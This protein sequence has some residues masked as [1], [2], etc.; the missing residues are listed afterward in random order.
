MLVAVLGP[1]TRESGVSRVTAMT[2]LDSDLQADAFRAA[3]VPD[4]LDGRELGAEMPADHVSQGLVRP[5]HE[6]CHLPAG[7]Q[8][9]VE[10]VAG[11]GGEVAADHHD[12]TLGR[13]QR[14]TRLAAAG[15]GE[16]LLL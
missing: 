13:A 6:G 3:V 14:V 8:Q 12:V 15:G 16:R 11:D 9:P 10:E 4:H 1:S 7:R 5:D 2:S